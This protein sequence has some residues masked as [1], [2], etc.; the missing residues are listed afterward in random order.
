MCGSIEYS[1]GRSVEIL[2]SRELKESL[3]QRDTEFSKA[4]R[5]H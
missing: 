4:F 2:N 5:S 1:I 3:P